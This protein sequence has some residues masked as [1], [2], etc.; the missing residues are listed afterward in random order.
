MSWFLTLLSIA[1][2]IL[3]TKQDRRG[4][5]LWSV[6]NLGWLV[7]DVKAELYSQAFLFSVY[8]MLSIWGL[9]TWKTKNA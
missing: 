4:F 7:V 3:V 5:Y 2:T 9:I 1:G 8:L 6:A